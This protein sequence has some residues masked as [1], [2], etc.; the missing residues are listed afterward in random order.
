[1][2]ISSLEKEF[3]RYFVQLNE[4]QKKTML[5]MMKAFIKTG[6]EHDNISTLEKYNQEIDEAMVRINRGEYTTLEELEKEM[7]TW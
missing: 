1:M 4:M 3:F 7:E 6:N 2:A 5:E